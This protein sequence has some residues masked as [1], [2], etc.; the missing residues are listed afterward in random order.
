M[1]FIYSPGSTPT[2]VSGICDGFR[3]P[4]SDGIRHKSAGRVGTSAGA[5]GSHSVG[6]M[7]SS[8]PTTVIELADAIATGQLAPSEATAAVIADL[9]ARDPTY[10]VV[11]HPLFERAT[12]AARSADDAVTAGEPLGPLHGVPVGVKDLYDIEGHPTAAGSTILAGSVADTT[13]TAVA[14]LEAAGAVVVAKITMTEFAGAAHNPALPVPVNPYRADHSP[15]GSSSGSGVAVAARMLPAALG[16][17]TVASIRLPAAFDG[18][19]GF[20]PS[21]GRVSRAGVFPLAATYDHCGPLTTTVADAGVVT[22][23]IAGPDPRD[24]TTRRDLPD[25][26]A[27]GV[28][29]LRIGFDDAFVAELAAPEVAA[30]AT[31]AAEALAGAGAEVVEVSIP[32]RHQ[33]IE[34]YYDLLRAEV[35]HAHGS[36]WPARRDDYTPSFGGILAA[37]TDVTR[38]DVV[39]AHELRIGFRHAIDDLFTDVDALVTPSF[40]LNAV[41]IT[42]DG[43][44]PFDLGAITI[45][46]FTWLWNFCGA[47]AVSLPWG[48]DDAGLPNSVQAIA[49]PGRDGL[50]LTVAAVIESAAPEL[51][52]PPGC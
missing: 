3:R 42:P 6:A 47:P 33:A 44:V 30:C 24:P 11:A 48:I 29:G 50:A 35:A 32:L 36:L 52:P 12:E 39:A 51:P 37:A 19:V 4:I 1:G 41:P 49:A 15:A 9:E 28:A 13:A 2:D 18:C 43:D 16:S 14:N 45:L 21:Y 34:P 22:R 17:D 26:P 23:A 5:A 31:A 20:K 38:D 46:Q 8:L 7:A 27:P 25:E 10:R 40:P